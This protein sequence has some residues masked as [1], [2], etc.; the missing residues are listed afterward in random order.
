MRKGI[1]VRRE[2]RERGS[3]TSPCWWVGEDAPF[4]LGRARMSYDFV[5]GTMILLQAQ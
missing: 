1:R 5:T 2:G 4:S 3:G